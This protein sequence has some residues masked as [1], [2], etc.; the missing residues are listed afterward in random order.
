MKREKQLPNAIFI[1]PKVSEMSEFRIT[2]EDVC[3]D[4]D[5]KGINVKDASLSDAIFDDTTEYRNISLLWN[6]AEEKP[7]CGGSLLCW[8]K[9]N[10]FFVHEH[11]CHD[12]FFWEKFIDKYQVVRYCHIANLMPNILL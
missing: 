6:P 4:S 11:Y 7:D 9:G 12:D 1:S 10:Y 2:E 3:L 8:C 5:G